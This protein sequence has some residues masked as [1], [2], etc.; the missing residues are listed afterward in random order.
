MAKKEFET[1]STLGEKIDNASKGTAYDPNKDYSTDLKQQIASG[2][3]YET[4]YNTLASRI[5][6]A[7][8]EGLSQYAWDSTTRDAIDYLLTYHETPDTYI[9]AIEA[10]NTQKKYEADVAA[11]KAEPGHL[12]E[13][14]AGLERPIEE[15]RAQQ[16]AAAAENPNKGGATAKAPAPSVAPST[17]TVT[18]PTPSTSTTTPSSTSQNDYLKQMYEEKKKAG[19]AALKAAYDKNVATLDA[20]GEKIPG[21]Y[22]TA[23]NRTAAEAAKAQRN[24]NQQA[25]ASGL[26]SGASAQATLAN[27]VALQGNL[28]TINQAEADAL[29]ELELQRTNAATEYENAIAE[30]EAN[31][32]YELAAA[33]YQEKVRVDELLLAQQKQLDAQA[34]QEYKNGLEMAQYLFKNTGDASGL[35]A[36]GYS[37]EQ[38]ANL[39]SQ[40]K[41]DN[42][43]KVK[44]PDPYK[45]TLTAAQ[46]IDALNNGVV[47]DTTLAAYQHY[48]GQPWKQPNPDL[49]TAPAQTIDGNAW[50]EFLNRVKLNMNMGNVGNATA[51]LNEYRGIMS[52]EQI[53]QVESII[54]PTVVQPTVQ[55]TGIDPDGF[56][57]VLKTIESYLSNGRTADAKNYMGSVVGR[58]NQEQYNTAEKLFTMYSV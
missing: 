57:I 17:S 32:N 23:R 33:L 5:N 41:I 16:D 39:Q 8:N 11:G 40:W 3:D 4:V 51:L 25:V 21:A 24:F 34:Q 14:I 37:D 19:L 13:V 12:A 35:R 9:D 30:A 50:A 48:F 44:E 29:A 42:A 2:A 27:S 15:L 58:M 1:Y 22:D 49:P 47:N 43:P 18:T 45:P 36:Y 26:S 52:P 28:N 56:D 31:G 54:N 53:A 6:K 38:I 7:N 20:A 10:A 55:P 46:V